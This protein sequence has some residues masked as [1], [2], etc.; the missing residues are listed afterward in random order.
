MHLYTHGMSSANEDPDAMAFV[1]LP[2]TKMAQMV[3]T[4]HDSKGDNNC[5][6]KTILFALP[7]Q[8]FFKIDFMNKFWKSIGLLFTVG[9]LMIV[10]ACSGGESSSTSESTSSDKME[11]EGQ[12]Q[13]G[14]EYTSAYVCPMHCAG[15]GSDQAGQCPVCKMDY[16]VNDEH[17]HDHDHN[18]HGHDHD[19]HDHN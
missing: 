4:I 16:V 15:S 9:T 12:N 7:S 13:D 1:M 3:G 2:F 8:T 5:T 11:E 17:G 18:G 14:P 10:V 6:I 19:G